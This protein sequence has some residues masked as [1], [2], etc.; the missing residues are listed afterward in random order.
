MSQGPS[1]GEM[2]TQYVVNVI[3]W[4]LLSIY[5]NFQVETVQHLEKSL[6]NSPVAGNQGDLTTDS[7]FQVFLATRAKSFPTVKKNQ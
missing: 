2:W 3:L 6:E 7:P 4:N 1:S 5:T